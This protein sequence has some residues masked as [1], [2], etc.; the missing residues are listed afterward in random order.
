[1]K[2]LSEN[3]IV[4]SRVGENNT[5]V[6]VG[7]KLRGKFEG[8]TVFPGGKADGSG[9]QNGEAARELQEETDIGIPAEELTY[10]GKLL[11]HDLRPGHEAFGNVFIFLGRVASRVTALQ[12]AELESTWREIDDPSF[13]DDMP[14]DVASWWPLVKEFNGETFVTHVT[15]DE[16]G[17]MDVITKL[18]SFQNAPEPIIDTRHFPAN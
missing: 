2:I 6:L 11:I 4:V 12:T 7:K 10:A 16:A 14:V 17:N 5:E 18:P 13:T 1:M 9:P 15:N 8:Q 3:L